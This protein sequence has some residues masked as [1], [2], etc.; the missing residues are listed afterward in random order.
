[1]KKLNKKISDAVHNEIPGEVRLIVARHLTFNE[2]K[3]RSNYFL[4]NREV[5]DDIIA[6]L[7]QYASTLP[8]VQDLESVNAL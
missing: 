1:M 4:H 7:K 3:F 5:L 6:D 8:S 2:E